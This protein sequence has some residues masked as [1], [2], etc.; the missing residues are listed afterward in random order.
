[1][2]CQQP[3]LNGLKP[4]GCRRKREVYKNGYSKSKIATAMA[5]TVKVNKSH[6][7]QMLSYK[8][9]K[10]TVKKSVGKTRLIPVSKYINF[11][12]PIPVHPILLWW[13][14]FFGIPSSFSR[15]PLLPTSHQNGCN[16]PSFLRPIQ[17]N[18][19]RC[20]FHRRW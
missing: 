7:G 1:M 3:L 17:K 13:P 20:R 9:E 16:S 11:R 18:S 2:R 12:E 8:K 4:G 15:Y 5:V 10:R 6:A 14:D 19:G